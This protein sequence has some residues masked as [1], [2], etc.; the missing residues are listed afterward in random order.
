MFPHQKPPA[1]FKAVTAAY[2]MWQ[3]PA[4]KNRVYLTFDDGPHPEVTLR[5]MET[6]QLFNARATFFVQGEKAVRHTTI[7]ETL[8][9][10]GHGL[11]SHGWSHLDGWTTKLAAYLENIEKLGDLYPLHLFR[12]PYGRITPCQVAGLRRKKIKTVMWSLSTMD[13]NQNVNPA[14][15]LAFLKSQITDGSIIL[16]HDTPAAEHSLMHILPG[17][18]DFLAH[19]GYTTAVLPGAFMLEDLNQTAKFDTFAE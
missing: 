9:H 14:T 11:G 7:V 18:L 2:L 4:G 17:M 3:L 6:L 19:R 12:P 15:S 5:L 8:L 13:H 16:M 10:S 1:W